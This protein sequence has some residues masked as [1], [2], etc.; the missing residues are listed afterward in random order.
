MTVAT[1]IDLL[2]KYPS[3]MK[4][5]TTWESTVNEIT[6]KDVYESKEGHLYIDGDACFYKDRFAKDPNENEN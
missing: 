5:F 1:L 4:V 6:K 3:D 2:K